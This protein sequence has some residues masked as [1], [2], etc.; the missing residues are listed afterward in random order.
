MPASCHLAGIFFFR[1]DA[2]GFLVLQLDFASSTFFAMRIAK[3]A[4]RMLS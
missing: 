1:R 3:T 4:A 2:A